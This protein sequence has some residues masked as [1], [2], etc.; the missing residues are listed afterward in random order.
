MRQ[1]IDI[2]GS[3]NYSLYFGSPLEEL[4][5]YL[6]DTFGS[7][8]HY[9]VITN[10][11]VADLYSD[12]L[13][14]GLRN[15]RTDLIIIPDGEEEKSLD[16]IS[17][18]TQQAILCRADRDTIIL[19]LGGGVVGDLAGFFASIFMRGVRYIQIPTTLLAQVDSS[20]GGKVA[21]NHPSGKNLLGAFYPP[22]SIWADFE[23][24]TTLPWEQIQDG[25]AETIKHALAADFALFEFMEDNAEKIL[26]RDQKILKELALRS[27]AVK[28]KIVSQD[29][30]EKGLRLILNL[31]HSFGHAIE[32]DE[33]YRGT[34]H[35]QG[36]SI[37]IV[38]AS[39]LALG[40]GLL[41]N[42]QLERIV[43]L[44][45]KMGLPTCISER[46]PATLLNHMS[47]DKKNKAGTKILILPKGLGNSIV[48]PDC[49]D[50]EIIK[51]WE[52][53]M[54]KKM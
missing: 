17:K 10:S 37:G 7:K 23:T 2:K 8:T 46:N 16:R 47:A 31:G 41:N 26:V 18:L 19:A 32:T 5:R 49:Y 43:N 20:I 34:S 4:G 50:E 29:E 1:K 22:Q 52:E 35:G 39:Y 45:K 11:T 3:I 33:E 15:F 48:V 28:V 44:I 51:T 21:V 30:K 53:I 6:E 42:L 24:L 25:L 9:L 40:R 12:R 14:N 13:L 36:V 27:L 54:C 38:A